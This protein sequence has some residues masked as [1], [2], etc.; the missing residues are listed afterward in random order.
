MAARPVNR[1]KQFE[2]FLRALGKPL[3]KFIIRLGESTQFVL[4]AMYHCFTPPFYLKNWFV[5]D[6]RQKKGKEK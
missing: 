4:K 1:Q 5:N 2:N 3:V 6:V